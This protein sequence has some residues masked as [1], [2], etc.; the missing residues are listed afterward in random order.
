MNLKT[1]DKVIIIAGR[2]KGKTGKINKILRNEQRVIVEG[3][4]MVKKHLKPDANNQS[5]S[6][7]DKEAPIHISN[8][9]LIDPKTNSKTRVGYEIDKKGNKARITKKSKSK[10]N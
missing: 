8:I 6:I 2:D 5:G 9:M 10:L 7:I 3:V 1:G 4:N